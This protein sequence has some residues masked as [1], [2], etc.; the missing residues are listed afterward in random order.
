M[1]YFY[2]IAAFL[3]F[4]ITPSSFAEDGGEKAADV[5]VKKVTKIPP[6][7]QD[8]IDRIKQLSEDEAFDDMDRTIKMGNKTRLKVTL[9][10]YPKLLNRQDTFGR[11]PLYNAVYAEQLDLVTYLLSKRAKVAIANVDGDTPLHRAAA[12][13]SKEILQLL[14]KRGALYYAKNKKGRTPLF[15]A[16]LHGEVEVAEVLLGVGDRV[17][18]QDKYGDTPLHLASSKGKDKM[19]KF[20]LSNGADF[21]IKNKRGKTPSDLAKNAKTKQLFSH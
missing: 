8:L 9:Y 6:E 11:T 10:I 4:L 1:K 2:I 13:G 20:L 16:A 14:L 12:D 3:F 21:T 7:L 15:N 19:V 5:K 18:R 17:N